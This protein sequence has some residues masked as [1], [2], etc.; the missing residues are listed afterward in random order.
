MMHLERRLS[1]LRAQRVAARKAI[2]QTRWSNFG[3]I[4]DKRRFVEA[5]QI[6]LRGS[7]RE[8]EELHCLLGR[9]LPGPPVRLQPRPAELAA[10]QRQSSVRAAPV[11]IKAAT[12]TGGYMTRMLGP[13]R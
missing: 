12:A 2:E 8:W 13:S 7:E 10:L 3:D 4:Y 5:Q 1:D 9:H 6:F 11:R